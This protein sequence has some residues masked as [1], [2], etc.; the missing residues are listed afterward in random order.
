MVGAPIK[1]D[2]S[3]LI[4]HEM[5]NQWLASDNKPYPNTFGEEFEV[6]AHNFY[7]QN[8]SQNLIQEKKGLTTIDIPSRAQK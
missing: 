6:M 7:V 1:A 8:K 3:I 5:T 4:K 2:D